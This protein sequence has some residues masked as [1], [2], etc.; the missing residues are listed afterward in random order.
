MYK[1]DVVV[2][3]DHVAE[4]R[5]AFFYPLFALSILVPTLAGLA[6]ES[7]ERTCIFTSSGNE[8]RKCWS[9]WSVVLVGTKRPFRFLY[10]SPSAFPPSKNIQYSSV[11]V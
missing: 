2:G 6:V 7:G 8:L 4:G 3:D 1:S 5:E 10:S 11:S 9:S